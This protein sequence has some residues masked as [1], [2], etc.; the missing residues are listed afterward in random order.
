[1]TELPGEFEQAFV[2]FHAAVAEEAFARADQVDERLRQPA[3][4]LVVIEI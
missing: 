4:R 2:G 1:V 3:L